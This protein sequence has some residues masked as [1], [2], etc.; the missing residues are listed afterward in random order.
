MIKAVSSKQIISADRIA[1]VDEEDNQG[2]RSENSDQ[3][4]FDPKTVK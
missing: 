3:Q 1:E 4:Y 2:K